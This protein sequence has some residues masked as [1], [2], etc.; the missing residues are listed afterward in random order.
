M[1]QGRRPPHSVSRVVRWTCY[2]WLRLVSARHFPHSIS[3]IQSGSLLAELSVGL[4]HNTR[5]MRV[6]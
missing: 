4:G 6:T 1:R 2:V 3:S 5:G